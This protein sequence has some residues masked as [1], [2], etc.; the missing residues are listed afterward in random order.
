MTVGEFASSEVLPSEK[1]IVLF[2]WWQTGLQL[3]VR[4]LS[5]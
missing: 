4:H 2:Y 5:G 1:V 3:P